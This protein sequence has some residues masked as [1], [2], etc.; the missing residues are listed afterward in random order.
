MN[1]R[2]RRTPEPAKSGTRMLSA[3]RRTALFCAS[4]LYLGLNQDERERP[5]FDGD[6]IHIAAGGR[7][8]DFN[9]RFG[10]QS[11][12][13]RPRMRETPPFTDV[14]QIELVTGQRGGLLDRLGTHRGQPRIFLTNSLNEYWRGDAS[15]IHTDIEGSQDIE[16]SP[17]VRIYHYA[18]TDSAWARKGKLPSIR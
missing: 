5:V 9:Q 2:I 1:W 15:L 7:S 3:H 10:Q 11:N 4:Y 17:Q 16:P 14:P 18:G 13:L 12:T 6:L 8:A